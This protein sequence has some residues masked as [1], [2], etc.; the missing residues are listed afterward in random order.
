[1][2]TMKDGFSRVI[3]SCSEP[4]NVIQIYMFDFLV[5]VELC[6][7]SRCNARAIEYYIW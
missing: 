3:R 6:I 7:A 2:V 1:M 4:L 5:L